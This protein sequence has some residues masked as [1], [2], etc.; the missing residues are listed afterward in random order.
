MSDYKFVTNSPFNWELPAE[1]SI[2]GITIPSPPIATGPTTVRITFANMYGPFDEAELFV[3]IGDP[4]KPT[5]Q[6]DVTAHSDWTKSDLIEELMATED[7]TIFR[8]IAK[9]PFE[10][11]TP[12]FATYETQLTFP[13]GR[14]AI[15]IKV[16]SHREDLMPSLVLTGWD[17][18]VG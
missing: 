3:R 6:D 18:T 12:W 15:E 17:F 5:D 4:D 8:A 14:H 10:D 2:E 1:S 16:I 11:E 9:E 7:G 13:A